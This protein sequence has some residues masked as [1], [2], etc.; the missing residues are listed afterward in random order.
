MS[1]VTDITKIPPKVRRAV[2]RRDSVD[3]WPCCIMC[4]RPGE[5]YKG[6]GLHLHHVELRSQLGK[7]E[8]DNLVTLCYECH[9]KLH[10]GDEEI[11]HYAEDY[12]R[13]VKKR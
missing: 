2:L 11:Q 1:V 7:G 9:D 4:G 12:L 10:D 6:G 8:E 13:R 5:N 3:D